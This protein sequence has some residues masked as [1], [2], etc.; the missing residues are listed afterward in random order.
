MKKLLLLIVPLVL[1]GSCSNKGTELPDFKYQTLGGESIKKAD[2]EGKIVV[3]NVW[4]TWCGT[5]IKEIPDLNRLADKYKNDDEVLFLAFSDEP[6]SKV[7]PLLQRFPFRY[8]HIVDAEEF[9]SNIQ[10]RLVKTYPQNL[11][12]NQESVVV[13]DVSDGTSD[14]FSKMDGII[15]ELKNK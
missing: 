9:T 5:C 13:F 12:V 8:T 2:L 10:T 4:A 7:I 1:L 15:Q 6:E 14:L 3:L 11:I